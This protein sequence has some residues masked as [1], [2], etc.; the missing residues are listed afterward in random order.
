LWRATSVRLTPV[1]TA[2]RGLERGDGGGVRIPR[3]NIVGQLLLRK[4]VNCSDPILEP[5]VAR[6]PGDE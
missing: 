4:R 6:D 3:V 5:N 2:E 1:A